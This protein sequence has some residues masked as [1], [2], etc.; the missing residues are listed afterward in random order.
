MKKQKTD[1][2]ANHQQRQTSRYTLG[3]WDRESSVRSRP[4]VYDIHRLSDAEV[5]KKNWF[6]PAMLAYM[7]HPYF[8]SANPDSIRKLLARHLIYFLDYTTIL[9]HKI[10]NR[11]VET[12]VHEA[13]GIKTP[14]EMRAAGLQLYTDEGYHAFF[15]NQLAEQVAKRYTYTRPDSFPSRIG[16]LLNLVDS[17]D[18]NNA[19]LAYFLEGFVSETIIA[20]ELSSLTSDQLIT[21]VYM[22]FRDHLYD[23]AKH[24]RFFTRA[25]IYFLQRMT[26]AQ[27]YFAALTLPK[28][29][30]IYFKTD[31]LWLEKSLLGVGVPMGV[32]TEILEGINDRKISSKTIQG[33]AAA[34]ISA[35]KKS[36]AFEDKRYKEIFI[37]EGIID[38]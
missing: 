17:V 3:D 2:P 8:K 32:T 16:A 21:P 13:L 9:E 31:I 25:F 38:G 27:K 22:M 26:D 37:A 34:T 1:A 30:K 28:I 5:N 36:G 19:D 24:C 10:V 4:N 6:P 14:T 29:I 23:E 7:Q 18:A 11:A 33:S 20:K 15:S 35:I 12:I